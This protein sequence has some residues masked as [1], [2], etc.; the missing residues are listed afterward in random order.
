MAALCYTPRHEANRQVKPTM[1]EQ[2]PVSS[3]LSPDEQARLDASKRLVSF[4]LL[5]M[6]A[7]VIGVI[8]YGLVEMA[9]MILRYS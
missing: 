4:M 9:L 2:K 1:T 3:T 5:A 7:G 6:G 8:I